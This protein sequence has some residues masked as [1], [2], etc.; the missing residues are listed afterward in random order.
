[1]VIDLHGGRGQ[2]WE[3]KDGILRM[4]CSLRRMAGIMPDPQL[5]HCWRDPSAGA[6]VLARDGLKVATDSAV[7][8]SKC[9][10]QL[11]RFIFVSV[12]SLP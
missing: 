1:M 4:G 6:D 7:I 3:M 10:G 9:C 2:A 8:A 12:A 11:Q 5:L